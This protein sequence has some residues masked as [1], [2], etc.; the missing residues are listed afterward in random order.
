MSNSALSVS[1]GIESEGTEEITVVF[2]PFSSINSGDAMLV[3]GCCCEAVLM[4]DST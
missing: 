2:S 4:E 1:Q 3:N